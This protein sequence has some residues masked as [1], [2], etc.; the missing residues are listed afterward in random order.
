MP[1]SNL[2]G[3]DK[4]IIMVRVKNIWG[5]E[6][7]VRNVSFKDFSKKKYLSS[8][9][10]ALRVGSGECSFYYWDGVY[11]ANRR[12]LELCWACNEIDLLAFMERKI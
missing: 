9:N 7:E 8:A 10:V 2:A 4:E 5:G 1:S 3:I 6:A 11:Y 12:E